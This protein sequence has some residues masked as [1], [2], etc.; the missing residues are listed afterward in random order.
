MERSDT[1]VVVIGAGAA[2]L[3][4]ARRLAAAH[5]DCVLVEARGR[6][7]GRAWTVP[8]KGGDALDL[9]CGWLHS[10]DR[11]PWCAIAEAQGATI[12]KS[13]PPW[14][15]VAAQPGFSVEDQM[16]FAEA[17]AAFHERQEALSET[18]PDVPA[19]TFLDPEG[20]WNPLIDAI[21]TYYSGVE[22]DR[23]SVRDFLRYADSGI[24][25]R[26]REGYGA[27][28]AAHGAGLDV[29]LDCAVKSIDH[30]GRRIR[31]E[32]VK[33]TLAADAVIVT[34]P[35]SLLAEEAVAFLPALPEKT[36]AAAG[37][38]LGLAD[39]LFLSLDGAEEFEVDSRLFGHAD[40]RETAAYHL[41]PLGRPE[42]EVYFGGAL[43]AGLEAAGG[44]AFFDFAAGELAG[45]FGA[46]FVSRVRPIAGHG[47]RSD[48]FARGSYSYALPG[49]ADCR[50]RLA[51]PVD[52]R[53]FFAGE[54]CSKR[55]FSTAHGAYRTGIAAADQAIAALRRAPARGG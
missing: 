8:A 37:L 52:G 13:P 22:L 1:E 50:E 39:K 9:G 55:D 7:G 48:P 3:A 45:L 43:A 46:D 26:V 28:I 30:S 19:S 42:I 51:E 16:A 21:S 4:A 10:A 34:L 18:D 11:N 54:A 5:V 32:T 15:R 25:W 49:K 47:W 12:D 31:V 6:L 36:E 53:L 27:V 38:P 20:R 35:S 14:E 29:V 40:R 44:G 33:G 24:N 41:R 23:L 2:G 17:M